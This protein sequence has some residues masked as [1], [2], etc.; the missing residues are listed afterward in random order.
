MTEPRFVEAIEDFK[1]RTDD[2]SI[3]VLTGQHFEVDH[4]VVRSYP[5]LFDE[6]GLTPP[7]SP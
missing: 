3:V 4:P 5:W 6:I 7:R 2:G 1:A